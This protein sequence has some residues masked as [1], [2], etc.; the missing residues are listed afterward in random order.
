MTAALVTYSL[1]AGFPA[2]NVLGRLVLEAFVPG[3]TDHVLCLVVVL[4]CV[5]VYVSRISFWLQ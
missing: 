2:L 1:A 3:D 4:A 5:H